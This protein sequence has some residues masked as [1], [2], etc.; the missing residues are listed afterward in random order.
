MN[1][2]LNLRKSTENGNGWYHW[3]TLNF[4][5][6]PVGILTAY[7]SYGANERTNENMVN[8]W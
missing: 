4:S 6:R 5:I 7:R 1:D 8:T 3:K 2:C